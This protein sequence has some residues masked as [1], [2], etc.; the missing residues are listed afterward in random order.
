MGYS[1]ARW[2]CG[3]RVDDGVWMED[4]GVRAGCGRGCGWKME[5]CEAG[6][7]AKHG[8]GLALSMFRCGI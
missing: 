3:P 4:G 1:D 2:G 8:A 6:V 7:D 5:G